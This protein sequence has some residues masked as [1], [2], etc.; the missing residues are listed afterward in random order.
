MFAYLSAGHGSVL[1]QNDRSRP[2]PDIDLR[3]SKH[4]IVAGIL[5]LVWPAVSHQSHFAQD[6]SST[7]FLGQA[8]AAA[9]VAFFF[10]RA[11]GFFPR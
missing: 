7:A 8:A 10:P 9:A 2:F 4:S 5:P 3:P 1:F 6:D 11:A